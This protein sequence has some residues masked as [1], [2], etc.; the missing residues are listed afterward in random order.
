MNEKYTFVGI[1]QGLCSKLDHVSVLKSLINE[2]RQT[3]GAQDENNLKS[4][5]LK[6]T[7]YLILMKIKITQENKID[8]KIEREILHEISLASCQIFTSSIIQVCLDCWSWI[9]SSRPDIEPLVVEEMLNAWQLSADMRLGMFSI[10]FHEPNPL[11]K[12]ELDVL[13]PSPPSNIETHR[14]WIRYL[15]ER[16]EI[17]RY[18]SDFEI[19]LFFNL[20][21]KT[22]SV[23][24]TEEASDSFLNRHISCIGL[25]FRYLNM[26]LSIVQ[27]LP[28]LSMQNSVAKW[29]LRERIYFNGLDYFAQRSFRAPTQPN[30][31]LRDDIKNLIEFWNKIVA[32]KKYLKEENLFLNI[33]ATVDGSLNN[34]NSVNVIGGTTGS[35]GTPVDAASISG[36]D[37]GSGN[38]VSTIYSSN[39]GLPQTI[40]DQTYY[41][42]IMGGSAISHLIASSGMFLEP[43][44]TMANVAN[45]FGNNLSSISRTESTIFTNNN[46]NTSKYNSNLQ[47]SNKSQSSWMNTLSKRQNGN[48]VINLIFNLKFLKQGINS[49]LK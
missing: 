45:P 29:V 37:S 49:C 33:L 26:A 14:I 30:T 39:S 7:A 4:C 47:Q 20:M 38:N 2:I 25:R 23:C 17:A 15:Q 35:G 34:T 10:Y 41:G 9:I 6:L 36:I 18:K 43:N 48:S 24:S 22:L 27:S 12:E 1:I 11:A 32:E 8:I 5:I 42:C 21:H 31:D 40:G 46:S 44:L 28:N 13:R 3:S 16:L 19:E